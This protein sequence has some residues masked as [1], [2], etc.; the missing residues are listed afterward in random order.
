MLLP[1]LL[2]TAL[3]CCV[4]AERNLT[5]EA[6]AFVSKFRQINETTDPL[7]SLE[8]I[9]A[10][11]REMFRLG[12]PIGQLLNTFNATGK[13][14]EDET[15]ALAELHR[16]FDHSFVQKPA[17]NSTDFGYDGYSYGA[18]LEGMRE[19]LTALTNAT[20][21]GR[22]GGRYLVS[23]VKQMRLLKGHMSFMSNPLAILDI[24]D[25][26]SRFGCRL[27]TKEGIRL[28]GRLHDAFWR[29]ELGAR[30]RWNETDLE[31]LHLF[32]TGLLYL[33]SLE[34]E[35][36]AEKLIKNL[37]ALTTPTVDDVMAV[38]SASHIEIISNHTTMMMT[39]CVLSYTLDKS[40]FN[41]TALLIRLGL[42]HRDLIRVQ[43]TEWAVSSFVEVDDE[44]YNADAEIAT[45]MIERTAN[46]LVKWT[47]TVQTVSWPEIGIEF[48]KR[49]IDITVNPTP[50][51][52]YNETARRVQKAFEEHGASDFSY[53][54]LIVPTT[55]VGFYWS[56]GSSRM[57]DYTNITNFNGLDIH[58]FRF[59]R[60]EIGERPAMAKKWM[61]NN[62][63]GLKKQIGLGAISTT[64]TMLSILQSESASGGPIY[65][66]DLFR[67]VL[68]MTKTTISPYKPDMPIGFALSEDTS[69]KLDVMRTSYSVIGH[70]KETI[71]TWKAFFF[72]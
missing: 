41:Q 6:R 51:A 54:V 68:L 22:H 49:A 50:A 3:L 28:V 2:A 44:S 31:S 62:V 5:A 11:S 4:N 38:M 66:D 34:N 20:E 13:A 70:G 37:D 23:H 45:M 69:H 1:T 39:S 46:F 55:R 72:L 10:N 60:T 15:K 29:V 8:K 67:S 71:Y 56:V 19:Y 26:N 9:G 33:I 40:A 14:T 35:E 57:Q 32:K 43:L 24:I 52:A 21:R 17:A 42:L 12:R 53:H 25:M 30:G 16:L 59:N 63:H 61:K 36:V 58:V 64:S 7:R 65:R 27:P 48:A 47:R 18:M